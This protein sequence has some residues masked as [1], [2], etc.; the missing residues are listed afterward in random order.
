MMIIVGVDAG[1]TKTKAVAYDCEGNFIGE[2][3]SGP[4][5][6]HNVGL[7]RAI[8]NIKE[9]VKIAAKGEA[10]VVGMGVAGLDSKFD[11]ENFTPLASLIAPKVI[12]QHDGVIAL[13]AETLGEP[14]VVVIAGTGSVVEG[15]NGK[16]FLRVGGRG[17]LLSDDG[18]AYWVGRKA[19]RKVLK[20]MDGLENKTILYNK[21]LKTINVKDLDELVMW[22]YTSSCQIDLVASIA[23]AVDEAANEGDTVAMDILK[24]GAELLASQA[25]YLARK[26]GTNKVYLKGGMFR[27]NIYHK[28]FTL[29][30]EKEGII[31]DLGKRSP[32]IGAV[33][34]AYKEVGCDIKKLISD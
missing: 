8:E 12:I 1:G 11:W 4:G 31:S 23:K 13:F 6:Y 10:D 15:Y 32:E 18:S 19:L 3:S 30:L 7:T 33:I 16:E 5:N 14:G 27:S 28:F 9:A 24:Q 26:I 22:S 34:L 21:V 29:Y 20:M 2:G 25:V 17:W